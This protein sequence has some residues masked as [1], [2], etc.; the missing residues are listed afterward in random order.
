MS[1]STDSPFREMMRD[2]KIKNGVVR[3]TVKTAKV[4]LIGRPYR[5]FEYL[6]PI[7][8]RADY[9]PFAGRER[10]DPLAKLG[11]VPRGRNVMF[12]FDRRDDNKMKLMFFDHF[13]GDIDDEDCRCDCPQHQHEIAKEDRRLF[14]AIAAYKIR[15]NIEPGGPQGPDFDV[16][17]EVRV[18]IVRGRKYFVSQKSEASAS[19][20][21][22]PFAEKE[23]AVLEAHGRWEGLKKELDEAVKAVPDA[24][25]QKMLDA[26]PTSRKKKLGIK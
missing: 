15:G 5:Y 8:V 19:R 21:P 7:K 18:K 22:K 9:D 11:F 24:E 10:Q 1:D 12:V 17:I 3:T 23:L 14:E 2:E 4:R 6:H 20:E 26:L 16:R 13:Q 25:I